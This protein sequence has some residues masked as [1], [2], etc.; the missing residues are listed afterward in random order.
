MVGARGWERSGALV[1]HG[2]R[3]SVL[4]DEKVLEVDS[5]DGCTAVNVPNV[6]EL[7]YKWFKWQ[8]LC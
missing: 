6:S 7:T 8:I 4:Q 3:V 5:G 2:C 1:F